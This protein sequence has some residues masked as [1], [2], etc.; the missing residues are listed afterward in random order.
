MPVEKTFGEWLTT[1]MIAM[2]VTQK[3]LGKE[4]AVSQNA[5]SSWVRNYREP[6]IRNF[7]W[8]CKLI[9]MHQN[10]RVEDVVLEAIEI[11]L[12]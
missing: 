5:I 9:A 3:E 11:F 8:L 10:K 12:Q 2:E 7:I 1:Q 6:K 4:I